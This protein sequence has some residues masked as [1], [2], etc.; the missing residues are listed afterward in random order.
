MNG[1]LLG[2]VAQHPV[3]LD[4]HGPTQVRDQGPP[5]APTRTSPR[6]PGEGGAVCVGGTQPWGLLPCRPGPYPGLTWS[7]PP[8]PDPW[9]VWDW[10]RVCVCSVGGG[11]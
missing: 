4:T 10:R 7:R 3:A 11:G 5:W 8:R 1:K 9:P 2:L 6:V